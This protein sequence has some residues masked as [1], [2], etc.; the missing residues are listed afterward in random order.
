MI[1]K[2]PANGWASID[3]DYE[4]S[5]G[6]CKVIVHIGKGGGGNAG[7]VPDPN[8][9][10][11]KK[12]VAPD[13]KAQIQNGQNS[14]TFINKSTTRTIIGIDIFLANDLQ[15]SIDFITDLKDIIQPGGQFTVPNLGNQAYKYRAR[16]GKVDANNKITKDGAASP[17]IQFNGNAGNVEIPDLEIKN[18]TYTVYFINQSN[19][20]IVGLDIYRADNLKSSVDVI[21][22][23]KQVMKPGLA[24]S[25]SEF[26]DADYMYVARYGTV[27]NGKV[28]EEIGRTAPTKFTPDTTKILTV[29]IV[30]PK[31]PA[32]KGNEQLLRQLL[33]TRFNGTLKDWE[34]TGFDYEHCSGIC[35]FYLRLDANGNFSYYEPD[36]TGKQVLVEK[37]TYSLNSYAPDWNIIEFNLH[38]TMGNVSFG[39]ASYHYAYD[40]LFKGM[41]ILVKV[42]SKQYGPNT[43]CYGD[44]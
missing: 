36:S 39:T 28:T 34:L 12:P 11:V 37:G 20:T 35:F 22:D 14:V 41:K 40:D 5:G 6:G 32:Q 29:H 3:A 38:P 7:N 33:V 42:N 44:C 16:Y 21:T 17:L 30:A 9:P 27:E 15:N 13:L 23:I 25:V 8:A 18:G 19:Y 24:L 4:I 1:L 43:L 26:Q 31:I 2:E 10:P